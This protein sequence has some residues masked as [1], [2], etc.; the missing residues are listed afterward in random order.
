MKY[1]KYLSMNYLWNCYIIFIMQ[2]F[3]EYFYNMIIIV[4][5]YEIYYIYIYLYSL[6][7]D[8]I[9]FFKSKVCFDYI[10]M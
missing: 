2:F 5:Y 4:K 6:K 7:Y 10:I 9:F 8:N 3:E 1:L